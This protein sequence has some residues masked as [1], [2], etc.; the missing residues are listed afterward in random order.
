MTWIKA[1]RGF[2]RKATLEPDDNIS[3]KE[4][5]THVK[6]ALTDACKEAFGSKPNVTKTGSME[7]AMR[8]NDW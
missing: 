2:T 1:T 3:V 8:S 4:H 5:W 6:T 7:M